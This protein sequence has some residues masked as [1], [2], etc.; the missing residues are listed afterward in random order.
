MISKKMII[1]LTAVWVALCG[2]LAVL[3]YTAPAPGPVSSDGISLTKKEDIGGSFTLV[4]HNGDEM[5]SMDI[6]EKYKLVFFGF[7]HC[8][9]IC[10]AGLQKMTMVLQDM[11]EEAATLQPVFISVDPARDTPE[12]V[13]DYL[14]NFHPRFIGF[15]GREEQV[16]EVQ[17]RYRVYAEKDRDAAADEPYLMDHS[18]YIYLT[19]PD[20]YVIDVISADLDIA[21]I[22]DAIV[23]IIQ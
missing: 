7:T 5:S 22:S 11:G 6:G 17:A 12:V 3:I 1:I 19:G 10:P 16:K 4:N 21:D 13:K 2:M 20:D 23:R 15:T 18:N 9:S 14:G 8:P